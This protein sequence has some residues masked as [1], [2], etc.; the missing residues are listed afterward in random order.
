MARR[1]FFS[2]H[3]QMDSWRVGQ[4]RNSW[5]LQKGETNRFMDAAAWEEVQR[6][7]APSVRAWIDQELNGTSV[8]VILIGQETFSRPFVLYEIEE[9]LK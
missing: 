4:V 1:V 9:S 8:T 2:F 7:G 5:L 3:H 6:K